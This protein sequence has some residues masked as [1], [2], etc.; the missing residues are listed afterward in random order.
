MLINPLT[1]QEIED[2]LEKLQ[3]TPVQ[4]KMIDE[5]TQIIADKLD[6]KLLSIRGF[7][8]MALIEWQKNTSRSVATGELTEDVSSNARKGSA[9]E[10]FDIFKKKIH[11]VV[12]VK[13]KENE[14]E[15]ALSAA[16]DYYLMNYASRPR[17]TK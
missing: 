9:V 7:Y 12:R 1:A 6:M 11:R 3:L 2:E 15:E 4:R 8:T 5:K 16:M 13:G 17:D 10:I 14:L